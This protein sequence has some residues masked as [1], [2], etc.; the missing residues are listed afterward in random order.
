MRVSVNRC[1]CGQVD[2]LHRRVFEIDGV[3]RGHRQ[4][5]ALCC[6]LLQ[7]V[8]DHLD[9]VHIE[10]GKGF[11]QDPQHGIGHQ[12]ACQCQA[13]LL[14]GREITRQH[15]LETVQINF[16]QRI[17]KAFGQAARRCYEGGLD[18]LETHA[19]AHLIGQF[20][21]PDTN[22]R[23]DKYGGSLE[24]RARFALMVHEEIRKNVGA[25]F[26]VG[27]R[28]SIQEDRGGL[29]AEDA[30]AIAQILEREGAI[31]FLN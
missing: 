29:S 11:I 15:V 3:V 20:F 16:I 2:A 9:A 4:H 5:A 18:G 6:V 14:A 28:M 10:R 19:G 7:Q 1:S 31:D 25:D 27:M 12:Q 30:I 22:R 23:R 24:N 21:S 26:L 8:L 17:V 13:T